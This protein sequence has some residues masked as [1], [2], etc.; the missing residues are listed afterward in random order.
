MSF[1]CWSRKDIH[2]AIVRSWRSDEW[3][4]AELLKGNLPHADRLAVLDLGASG[5]PGI[6]EKGDTSHVLDEQDEEL[7]V[8]AGN[9]LIKCTLS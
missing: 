1:S 3:P 5:I 7:K 2:A 6:R 8:L 9:G 4:V